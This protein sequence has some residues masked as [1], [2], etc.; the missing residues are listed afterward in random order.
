MASNSKKTVRR[1]ASVDNTDNVVL[2]GVLSVLDKNNDSVWTGT[3]TDLSLVLRR[4]VDKKSKVMLP[5]SSSAL[6][7]VMNRVVNRLRSRGVSVRFNRTTDHMRKRFV[8]LITR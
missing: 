8:K 2:Q 5:R 6:R 3:M 4:L 7:V 1:N